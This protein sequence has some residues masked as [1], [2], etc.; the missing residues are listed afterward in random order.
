MKH[1]IIPESNN[2][3]QVDLLEEIELGTNEDAV[4]IYAEARER[5]LHPRIWKPMTGTA[6]ADFKTPGVTEKAGDTHVSVGDYISIDIP[7]P[8]SSAGDGHDWVR[9]EKIEEGFDPDTDESFAMTM[10]VCENPVQPEKGV[11]HFFAE[12]AS[13]TF[14]ITRKGLKVTASYHGRNET[15]NLDNPTL[16]D[17]IRNA[18]VAVGAMAGVSELQWKAFLKGLLAVHH[19]Y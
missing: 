2:G 13:S 12:G 9:V 11:A 16:G 15:P 19:N 8:G 17:K 3:K 1:E 7:A 18:V 14:I 6:A 5:L 10:K 4:G